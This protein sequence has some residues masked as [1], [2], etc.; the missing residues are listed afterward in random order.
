MAP[1]LKPGF[2]DSNRYFG[3]KLETARMD[4]ALIASINAWVEENTAGRIRDLLP[5][6]GGGQPDDPGQHPAVCGRLGL[7]F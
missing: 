6:R 2:L 5:G 7:P 1:Y 3:A 4:G